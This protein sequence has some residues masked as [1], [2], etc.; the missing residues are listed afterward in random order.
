MIL[1]L[2]STVPANT[3]GIT[4][5]KYQYIKSKRYENVYSYKTKKGLFYMYKIR[6]YDELGKRKEKVNQ[7]LK[8]KKQLIES[9]WR[10]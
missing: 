7:D 8:M 3:G 9:H 5:S 4:M 6:Y 1:L 10:C 2:Y